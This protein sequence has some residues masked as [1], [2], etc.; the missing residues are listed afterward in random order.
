LD[1]L[2]RALVL[3]VLTGCASLMAL[4]TAGAAPRDATAPS[5][6]LVARGSVEQVA[7]TGAS[8]GE[9]LRLVASDGHVR[10]RGTS[11]DTGALL[12]R[13]VPP[14]TGYRVE[15]SGGARS[16]PL[17]VLAEDEHPPHSF[18][19]AQRLGPGYQYL[20]TRDG[21]QL[22]VNVRLPGPPDAGPYPTVVEYS[23]YDPANPDGNQ[24]AMRLAQILGYATVGVNMRGT[25][26]SGGAWDYFEPLQALDGYD[27]I[28]VVAAQPW[29]AH[30]A[31]GMVG[32]SYSGITQ[33]F[34]AA[35][36]PPHLA[37]ITPL[38]VIADTYRGVLYP[39]GILNT[40]FAVPWAE[41]R[42]SDA[43]P[44]PAGGQG[45]A[46]RR[47]QAGD[48]TC[49][50]NQ[51]L[52]E[53]TPDV[54][55]EI[56]ANTYYVPDRLDHATP[57]RLVDRIDVPTFLAGAWQDEQTG[58]YWPALIDHFA[59]GLPLK[60]TVTNGTHAEP[61]GPDVITRWA[62][63]LDF[64]VARR[65]PRIPLAVRGNAAAGY[66]A[67]AGVPLALPPDRFAGETDFSA[68]LARY[69]AEPEIRV[70]FDNGAG[71]PAPGAPVAAFETSVA[72]WP[73][74][75]ARPRSLYLGP[76]GALSAQRPRGT[77][78]D[79]YRY[80]PSALPKT[81]HPSTA[82]DFFSAR[83]AYDWK[84]L[85]A[86]RGAGYVTKPLARDTVV[87]GPV[88]A[89]LWLR[90]TARDT[91]LE[92]AITEVRPDGKE[93]Y[94]QSGWLRASHRAL[95]EAASTRLLPVPT[96]TRADT[97]PLPHKAFSLVRVPVFPVGHVFRAGSRIRVV[98]QPP[99]GNR[100]R[101]AF[102]ALE[103]DGNVTN[104]LARSPAHPSRVVLPV[105][106]DIHDPS[107]L[108]PCG[109]LRGQPCR[110]YVRSGTGG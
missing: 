35:T 45:W 37:A 3:L 52:R 16:A 32:I 65:V 11:D 19:A 59:P 85:P 25:G 12:L 83:P 63:F 87:L 93:T 73:P 94:V 61:F 104:E 23:G 70:L 90:S 98:V 105:V 17:R 24:A 14:G 106:D 68:A 86:G 108:P 20:T 15:G 72:A 88:S 58:G 2:R 46:K 50:A 102:Q 96:Y 26:C 76:S 80:D 89:D 77:G 95:D 41:D 74:P 79:A 34:V 97:S 10:A 107:P 69:E 4:P 60:V 99:G 5:P 47:V 49:A 30:G 43:S 110:E 8:P 53:Q 6:A 62:E 82:D 56:R 1:P 67:L 81:D 75:H 44:A 91:D 84:P 48:A 103:P 21:T 13:D 71:G 109:A 38:S 29:V 51:A 9:A 92:V 31:V 100:P 33:L 18:Y 22:A 55:A 57:T 36:R 40:G 54:L 78:A 28:E 66:I 7:I 42:Q 39:G 101:W 27:A 64:Y